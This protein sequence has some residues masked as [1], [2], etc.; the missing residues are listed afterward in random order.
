MTELPKDRI[1][2]EGGFLNSLVNRRLE[3]INAD[4][5][6]IAQQTPERV[7]ATKEP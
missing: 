1:P 3:R 7:P 2:A 5:K 4:Q 6:L